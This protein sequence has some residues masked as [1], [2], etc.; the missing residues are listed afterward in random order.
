MN[1]F[2]LTMLGVAVLI[3]SVVTAGPVQG[4]FLST[5]LGGSI[6]DGR[7]SEAWSG[8]QEGALGS[9]ISAASWN[10][11]T[12]GTMWEISGPA[13]D[14]PAT[15]VSAYT[16][17]GLNVEKWY[18]TYSGGGLQLKNTGPWWNTGDAG[19]EYDLT[20]TSYSHDTTKY[21]SGT[22]LISFTTNVHMTATFDD[23]AGY[24]VD[25]ILAVA[26]PTGFGASVPA[27]Y[28]PFAINTTAGAWGVAQKIRMEVVPE[29]ATLVLL[30]LGGLLLGK[31]R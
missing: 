30:G 3:S 13:I 19:T 20:V 7:W 24:S 5:E 11:T 2:Q 10:G 8:G 31:K 15:L 27:D 26:V 12:L 4:I 25:F 28:P 22:S 18:T 14:S 23:F 16:E 6:I 9:T 21:Y 29:P 17:Y 1:K